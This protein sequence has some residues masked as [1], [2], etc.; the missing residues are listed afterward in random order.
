MMIRGVEHWPTVLLLLLAAW[1]LVRFQ[2]A[3]DPYFREGNPIIGEQA[4][5]GS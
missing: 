1:F 4:F 3:G 2:E 5:Q